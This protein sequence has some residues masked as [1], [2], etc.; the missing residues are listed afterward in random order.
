MN[1]TTVINKIS[2]LG[3]KGLKDAYL[4]QMEDVNYHNISFEDRL[5][6]LLD[7][8]DIFI[9]NKK[10]SMNLKLSKIKDK[11]A[12][13]ENLDYVIY[14]N[15]RKFRYLFLAFSKMKIGLPK[16]HYLPK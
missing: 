1:H 10:V 2:E 9:N 13:L 7:A 15:W 11:Q 12:L 16:I 4:R 6:Q 8:Q 3:Y 14:L 5:Y